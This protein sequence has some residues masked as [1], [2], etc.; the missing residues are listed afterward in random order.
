MTDKRTRFVPTRAGIVNL[1]DY[2][3]QEFSFADGRLVLRGPNGSGKTKA[4]EVLF[5]F[6]FDGRIEPRRLNPFAGEERTMKSNL[7]YRKQDSAYSYVWM[8]FARGSRS[9][10]EAVTI[11]IGMRATRSSDKVTRWYFV[12]DGRVGVDF[13]LLGPDDRPFTRKQLAD[14]IGGDSITDRP[15][16][17]RAA[18]D[19]RMFGLGQQRFDQLINLILTLRRPQLAKNLDPKG[20]SQ[21]LTDGLRPLDEQLVTDAARSFSDMEEVGRS[22]EGLVQADTATRKFVG[23]YTRYLGVQAKTDVDQV[24][25]RLTTVDHTSTALFAAR[26][27]RERRTE[28]RIAAEQRLEAADHALDQAVANRDALHG[29]SAYES[30]QQLDDLADAV[31]RLETSTRQQEDKAV[32]AR[33]VASQ[34]AT[35]AERAATAARSTAVRL[36]RAEDELLAAAEDAGI[37][38]TPL[39]AHVRADQLTAAIRGHA[40]E[41]DGDVHA[42]RTALAAVDTAS[43]ERARAERATARAHELRTAAVAAVAEAEAAVELARADTAHAL[44][45]WWEQHGTTFD[46][47]RDGLFEAL[48]TV[49]GDAGDDD[50][51]ALADVLAERVEPLVEATRA[52]RHEALGRAAEASAQVRARTAERAEVAA[53]RDDAPPPFAARTQSRD[54]L[55]GAP[56]WQLVRF[57]DSVSDADAA[58]LEAA[59][60]AANILDGWISSGPELPPDIES[61]QFLVALPPGKRP[62]GR[63]LADVLVV[64]DNIAVPRDLVAAVLA[65]ISID[66]LDAQVRVG[67][68]GRFAQGV[69]QGRHR[70]S[71]AEFIGATARAHRRSLRL[72][73]LDRLIA[74]AAADEQAASA[75][76]S[77]AADRLAQIGI[78]TKALPRTV[79]VTAALRKVAEAAVMLRSRSESA[80][81]ADRELDQAVADLSLAEKRLR[82]ASVERRAPRRARELDALAAAIRHFENTGTTVL[83]SRS[84]HDRATERERE[85][86]DRNDDATSLAEELAIEAAEAQEGYSEQQH[87]LET[88]RESLGASAKEIDAELERARL[89][90]DAC[91]AEQRAARKADRES[92]EAVGKADG[93]YQTAVEGLRIAFTE[94]VTDAKRL[95]P[96]AHR[97][98]LALLGAGTDTRWPSTEAAWSTVEQMMAAT[99]AAGPNATPQ[100]LPPEVL[101][102]F[103]NLFTATESVRISDAARKTTRSAVTAAL[104]DFDA[105]LA[106]SG[107]EFALRWDD[108]DGLTVVQ[109][110]DEQG[111][112]S[113]ADFADRIDRARRE[114]ETLLTDAERRILEDALL[115]GLAQQIHERTVDARD[116]IARMGAEMKQRRMSSGN[117]IGVH[118]VLADTLTDHARSVSKLLD[119]DASMLGHDE[120]ATIRAHFASEIRAARAAHP[121]RSYPEILS[122]TLD[123]RRWRVFSFTLISGDGTEE[124]L[125]VARHSALS[126][127]EQ[128]VSL[129]LPLFAAAH[130]MLD[131]ADPQAPRLLALDEAFAG[132][133]DNGRSE[134]LGLSVQFDLDLFMT[135]YDLWIT[136]ADVPGCAH[137]DLAHSAAEN[138]VSATLLVWEDGELLAEHDGSD[139]AAALGSPGQ[140]RVPRAIEGGLD[141]A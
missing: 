134:L 96:Y 86:A 50:A 40:E 141:F 22:L 139:L 90:I 81:Y 37:T 56:L 18:I 35:E 123:Y 127:G 65:S 126:G 87:R 5:P 89:R 27:L 6:V 136:Y 36:A 58:G 117:T 1:W 39:P 137:Y 129:H 114:Q 98:I 38:W 33:D 102:L 120:L 100:I 80:G 28:E 122:T 113:I 51:V 85:A 49:L 45:R 57:A 94:I 132:V 3:D 63:T 10:P 7:L 42:V 4:L 112:S 106:K 88:L 74:A 79:A 115:T 131:S 128:S 75:E 48:A 71:D 43:S 109:V 46:E 29:S 133:D 23:V 17:Y 61:E 60:H 97:D 12:T 19:S 84:E 130:V 62:P 67:V 31:R 70:K 16:D 91:K 92:G 68:D 78:A 54:G 125:T 104:Q 119:R 13:S 34:R 138:T 41:R 59:L 44:R 140:R 82:T 101:E 14:E 11:G 52:R 135:G 73:E 64:E 95:A 72:A 55:S 110:V 105:Q 77:A 66:D 121:E 30:K 69:S 26:Q 47:V 99:E 15:V 24:Q 93:A 111:A 32:K 83:R 20:L 76:A 53:E 118:W 124:R 21:A 116:L 107:Q 103:Q 108:D 25:R 2:R 8:E 9:D